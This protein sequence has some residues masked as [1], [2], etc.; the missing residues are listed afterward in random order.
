MVSYLSLSVNAICL[1]ARGPWFSHLTLAAIIINYKWTVICLFQMWQKDWL[2]LPE[3]LLLES[4]HQ[5]ITGVEKMQLYITGNGLGPP[6]GHFVTRRFC[7]F[8]ISIAPS[9]SWPRSPHLSTRSLFLT[10]KSAEALV[11]KRKLSWKQRKIRNVQQNFH[12]QR[13]V[14]ERCGNGE[15]AA[16]DI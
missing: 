14:S 15:D 4:L 10:I 8:A 2:S 5:S 1:T 11:R 12:S 3:F 9:C 16:W 7:W 6:M 13:C